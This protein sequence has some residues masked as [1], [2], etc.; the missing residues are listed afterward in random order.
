[1]QAESTATVNRQSLI[2]AGRG[3]TVQAQRGRGSQ[4]ASFHCL[5]GG[6]LA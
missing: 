5:I 6:W 3:G 4:S 1:M 2:M